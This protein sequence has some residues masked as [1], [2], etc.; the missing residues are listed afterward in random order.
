MHGLTPFPHLLQR[1]VQRL[2]AFVLVDNLAKRSFGDVAVV[3]D[4]RPVHRKAGHRN[5]DRVADASE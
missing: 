5:R 1:Y 2:F 4:R 3:R